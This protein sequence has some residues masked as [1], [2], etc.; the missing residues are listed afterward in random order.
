MKKYIFI[1][2][3]MIAGFASYAQVSLANTK[4]AGSISAPSPV[5][6]DFVFTADK[7]DIQLGGESLEE[8]AY[9]LKGDTIT[10]KKTVGKSPCED[11]ST[12]TYKVVIKDDKLVITP[13]SEP[14]EMR[15]NAFDPAGYARIKEQ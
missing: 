9:T 11:G 15:G 5:D 10:V 2:G 14:C 7:F 12:A 3:L 4:W 6:V 13:I 8:M 1:L